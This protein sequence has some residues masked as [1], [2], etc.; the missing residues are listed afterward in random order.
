ME[1]YLSEQVQNDE[2]CRLVREAYFSGERFLIRGEEGSLAALVPV[3]DL[4]V[5]EEIEAQMGA[6]QNNKDCSRGV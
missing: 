5:I 1:R 3:E 6:F 4:E 2:I